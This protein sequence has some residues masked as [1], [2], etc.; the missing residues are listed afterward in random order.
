MCPAVK[1][2]FLNLYAGLGYKPN[3]AINL[4][5]YIPVPPEGGGPSPIPE[6]IEEAVRKTII[7]V[8]D[9]DGQEETVSVAQM[10][11]MLM[12]VLADMQAAKKKYLNGYTKDEDSDGQPDGETVYFDTD[13]R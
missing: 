10:A 1:K 2:Q 12:G 11:E 8:T 13:E 3:K 6:D 4:P 7:T 5:G 9:S